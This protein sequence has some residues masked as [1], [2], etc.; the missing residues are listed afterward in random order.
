MDSLI[1]KKKI[2]FNYQQMMIIYWKIY[3]GTL[4]WQ[5]YVWIYN[6]NYMYIYIFNDVRL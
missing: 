3:I 1:I 5:K 4:K 2:V 6:F